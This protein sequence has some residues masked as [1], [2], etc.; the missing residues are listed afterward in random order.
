MRALNSGVRALLALCLIVAAGGARAEHSETK[1]RV[2]QVVTAVVGGKNVFI[3]STIV[4]AAGEPTTLSIFNT[5]DQPHGFRISALEIEAILPS[6]Q[7]FTLEL[8]ALRGGQIYEIG[9]QLHPPHR[10]ATLAVMPAR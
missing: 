7:E 10:T 8:P 4:V 3:P 1:G 2:I 6:Q 5:T 9:C